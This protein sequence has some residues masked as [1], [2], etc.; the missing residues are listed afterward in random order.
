MANFEESDIEDFFIAFEGTTTIDNQESIGSS[1]LK[2]D[3]YVDI[4]IHL[5]S[6]NIRED[7][8][9]N[10][11]SVK[12]DLDRLYPIIDYRQLQISNL[13]VGSAIIV[14]YKYQY[15]LLIYFHA[16]Y[17]LTILS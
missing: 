1:D 14:I 13:E 5:I 4:M 9:E 3:L 11:S 16:D 6:Q 10:I 2:N 15:D 12:I 7:L 8:I 17:Y